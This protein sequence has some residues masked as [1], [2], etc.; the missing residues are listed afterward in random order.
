MCHFPVIICDYSSQCFLNCIYY[1]SVPTLPQKTCA[2]VCKCVCAHTHTYTCT[3]TF[4]AF[5]SLTKASEGHLKP[6]HYQIVACFLGAVTATVDEQIKSFILRLN[7]L[8]I[9]ILSCMLFNG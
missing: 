1:R 5:W 4:L 8:G 7:F 3:H 2:H 9:F 6:L